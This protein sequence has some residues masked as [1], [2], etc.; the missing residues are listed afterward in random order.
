MASPI[1]CVLDTIGGDPTSA[2]SLGVY[3]FGEGEAPALFGSEI[4]PVD[5]DKNKIFPCILA[6]YIGSSD[7]STR[8][9]WGVIQQVG[10][11]IIGA[12]NSSVKVVR[13]LAYRVA[14]VL[15]SDGMIP[16]GIF[17]T[18]DPQGYPMAVLSVTVHWSE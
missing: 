9:N 8:G 12:K 3:D 14:Y 2:D 4:I 1:Q 11:R 5:D 10:L 16:S 18:T 6:G 17:T 7:N 15:H 13:D